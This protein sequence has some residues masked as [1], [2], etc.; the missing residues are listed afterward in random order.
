[1]D[2][3][4]GRDITFQKALEMAAANDN[5]PQAH[6]MRV[7]YLTVDQLKPPGFKLVHQMN[8]S[9]FGCIGCPAEH[10]LAEVD[11]AEGHTV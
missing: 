9:H 5:G 2:L 8:E 1:M 10:G 7:L 11:F 3:L 4:E 6:Q